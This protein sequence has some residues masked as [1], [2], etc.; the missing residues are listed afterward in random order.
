MNKTVA[1]VVTATVIGFAAEAAL[2][3]GSPPYSYSQNFNTLASSGNTNAWTDDST[4]PGWWWDS[5][6]PAE[7][8]STATNGYDT[9]TGSSTSLAA[10]SFGAS[11]NG[12]RAM[13]ALSGTRTDF[14]IGVQFQ[15]AS[16][17]A[18]NLNDV[19]ISYVGEQW[20]QTA[21]SQILAFSYGTNSAPIAGSLA[22]G[23]TWTS[24]TSLDF[25]GPQAAG[26]GLLDGNLAANQVS[27]SNVALAATG[28]WANND[29][30][31]LRWTK[32]GVT[33]PGLAVDDFS[34]SIIPEPASFGLLAIGAISLQLFRRRRA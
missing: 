18:I 4:I 21:N 34:I 1:L 31:F 16:G 28:T 9:S 20:R 32:T 2:L 10:Y 19:K 29:Y 7:E 25:T 27:F 23:Q 3:V 15:N 11:G 12:E 14:Y 13:G 24:N 33:S 5:S 26:A 22:L 30:L 8:P 17:Q 6:A